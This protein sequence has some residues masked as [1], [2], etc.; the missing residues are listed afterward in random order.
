MPHNETCVLAITEY[1]RANADV[2]RANMDA[3]FH[4]NVCRRNFLKHRN[5]SS[6]TYVSNSTLVIQNIIKEQGH[7]GLATYVPKIHILLKTKNV[8]ASKPISTMVLYTPLWLGM[9]SI[10][11]LFFFVFGFFLCSFYL[12]NPSIFL[13]ICIQTTIS[14]E[15]PSI[16]TNTFCSIEK[17]K[18]LHITA[19]LA[20]L[21]QKF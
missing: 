10:I 1:W 21:F 16:L 7:N 20:L 4:W 18:V 9:V 11:S 17:F 19:N 13:L 12:F 5:L 6:R 14:P 3:V 15:L 8:K 2:R